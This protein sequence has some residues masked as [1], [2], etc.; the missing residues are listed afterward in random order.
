MEIFIES[1]KR[2]KKIYPD[3]NLKDFIEK[4]LLQDQSGD[5]EKDKEE[6]QEEVLKLNMMSLHGSKGLEFDTV[7]LIGIEE[8]LLPHKRCLDENRDI[9]E[10][11]RLLYVGITRARK[12]LIMSRCFERQL[13]GKKLTRHPSRFLDKMQDL[14]LEQNRVLLGHLTQEEATDY[15]KNF[16]EGLM[17]SISSS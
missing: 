11:R 17:D 13:Y 5:P 4:L 7:Y 2:F 1:A 9:E 3:A 8:E 16:F 6:E 15:K 14:Y 12:D 10:E